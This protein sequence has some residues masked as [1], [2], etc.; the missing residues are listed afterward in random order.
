MSLPE[1]TSQRE[2]ATTMGTNH[3]ICGVLEGGCE[4]QECQ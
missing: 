4:R 2:M 3:H 1:D